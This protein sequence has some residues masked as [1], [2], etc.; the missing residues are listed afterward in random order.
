MAKKQIRR[1]F[2]I[3]LEVEVDGCYNYNESD[4]QQML[5]RIA[6]SVDYH[7]KDDKYLVQNIYTLSIVDE[8]GG[9]LWAR[10]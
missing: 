2:Y 8:K 6:N 7:G 9:M 1:K 5:C 4:A 10:R 3:T